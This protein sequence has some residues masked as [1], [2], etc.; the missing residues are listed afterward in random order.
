MPLPLSTAVTL[1]GSLDSR[2]RA[3][4]RGF[5][6]D[7]K[8]GQLTE[9]VS[10][11]SRSRAGFEESMEHYEIPKMPGTKAMSWGRRGT[12]QDAPEGT[13]FVLRLAGGRWRAAVAGRA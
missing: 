4:L 9:H 6:S 2:S 1:T 13:W 3:A 7:D 10:S 12:A 11:F 8:D 5:G